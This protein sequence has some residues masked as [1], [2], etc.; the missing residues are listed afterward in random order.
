M[1]QIT[2]DKAKLENYLRASDIASRS[3]E[4]EEKKDEK[5]GVN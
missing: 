2:G 4:A 3:P 1:Q 5:E